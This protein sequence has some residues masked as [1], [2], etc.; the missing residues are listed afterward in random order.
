MSGTIESRTAKR[1][2]LGAP[3]KVLVKGKVI[4]A[5]I[6]VNISMGGILLNAAEPL[7]VGSQCEVSIGLRGGS[8]A[9]SFQTLGRVVRSGENGTAI[10]FAKMLGDQTLEVLAQ[11]ASESWGSSLVHAYVN[12][13]RVSQSRI[14]FD[15]ERVFGVTARTFRTVSTI[16]FITCI[17]AAVL[18]VWALRAY[19]P[20]NIPDWGKILAAFA[21]GAIWLL[22]LQPLVDLTIFRTLRSKVESRN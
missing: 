15:S 16:S 20:N 14:G 17:P 19:I 1:I 2:P 11:P 3:V 5:A 4:L 13:F 22:V 18:P 10:Q 7:P 6:A 8:G 9:D 12:Y 21:Y